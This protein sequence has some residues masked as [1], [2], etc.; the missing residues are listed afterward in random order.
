MKKWPFPE[1]LRGVANR[2]I[3]KNLFYLPKGS[4]KNRDLS[5]NFA[6]MGRRRR[7]ELILPEATLADRP[8]RG[9]AELIVA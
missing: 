7:R 1:E 9:K 6:G 5:F 2:R 8:F 3:L 4:T